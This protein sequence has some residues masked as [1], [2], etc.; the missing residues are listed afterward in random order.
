MSRPQTEQRGDRPARRPSGWLAGLALSLTGPSAPGCTQACTGPGCD[1]SFNAAAISAQLGAELPPRGALSPLDGWS[2]LRGGTDLGPNLS[3]LLQPGALWL[4]VPKL[5]AVTRISAR[6]GS[7]ELS[8]LPEA[9]I[10]SSRSGDSFGEEI[11]TLPDLDGDGEDELV[12]ASPRWSRSDTTR[13]GGAVHV[14]SG[15]RAPPAAGLSQQDALLRVEG[16]ENGAR[17]GTSVA[18]CPDIDGDGLGELLVGSPWADGAAGLEGA[19]TLLLSSELLGAPSPID[20]GA[21]GRRW[22]GG[23]VGA[24]AGSAVSCAHDLIGDS[25]PDLVIAAPFA[26]GDH[27][28]EG[29]VW[30]L[31]GG[32]LP[33]SGPLP[34]TGALRI[35]GTVADGWAGWALSTG[36]V[37]GD[38]SAD[39]AIGQPGAP[40]A[41]AAYGAPAAGQVL[42]FDGAALR[43]RG[44]TVPRVRVRAE[45]EGDA[46]GRALALA[47]LNG[48]GFAEL[49]IGAPRRNPKQGSLEFFDSGALYLFYGATRWLG[50]RPEVQAEEADIV[51]ATSQQYL[52]AG[53][54]I[55]IGDLDEDGLLDFAILQRTEAD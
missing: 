9:S 17:F 52:R 2:L 32:A 44:L 27:E 41:A 10:L 33:D 46:L 13:Q 26:D 37:D 8:A 19:A 43:D 3:V 54:R 25:A 53:Q 35:A 49:L 14:F 12:V 50:L 51:Y 48:D 28:A 1:N 45:A 30:V 20:A 42:L 40:E 34:E 36:D 18:G 16:A 11:T 38:G 29:A 6:A 15:L 31:D 5:G 24:A 21:V 23:G 55:S 22:T 7:R 39:L 47:D 4:G